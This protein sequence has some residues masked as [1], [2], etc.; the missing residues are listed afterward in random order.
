MTEP[1]PGRV[2]VETDTISGAVTT[3]T[4]EPAGSGCQVRIETVFTASG[5]LQGLMERWFAP[6]MLG[7]LYTDELARLDRY[8]TETAGR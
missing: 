1:E 6:Q 2:M 4:V 7:R 8:A 5:G 3:F